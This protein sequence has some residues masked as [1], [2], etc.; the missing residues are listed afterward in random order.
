MSC[1]R[2][3]RGSLSRSD[4]WRDHS[5]VLAAAG[6]WFFCTCTGLPAQLHRI[7][8]SLPKATHWTSTIQQQLLI[9][10]AL[11]APKNNCLSPCLVAVSLFD[12]AWAPGP[13]RRSE[14]PH[15]PRGFLTR[16]SSQALPKDKPDMPQTAEGGMPM[17][18]EDD[19]TDPAPTRSLDG[20]DSSAS[21]WGRRCSQR[22]P[23]H[24][25]RSGIILAQHHIGLHVHGV[26]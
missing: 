11:A 26:K 1:C 18:A 10:L 20:N 5:P 6:V 9:S 3:H 17:P 24:E 4:C 8:H 13:G 21:G 22:V 25:L 2:M 7:M 15:D 16:Q 23:D 14:R 12:R 19:T